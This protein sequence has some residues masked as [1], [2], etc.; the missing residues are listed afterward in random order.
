MATNQTNETLWSSKSIIN[1]ISDTPSN[2]QGTASVSGSNITLG[3]LSSIEY[4]YDFASS[5][6][7]LRANSLLVKCRA[8]CSNKELETRYT[9]HLTIELTIRYWKE[10]QAASGGY[11]EGTWSK[12]RV[13]PY[14]TSEDE[15]YVLD[16]PVSIK[17][18]YIN[19]II[20]KAMTDDIG[21]NTVELSNFK[22]YWEL[23]ISEVIGEYAGT[24]QI[25][26]VDTYDNG[27]V[28]YYV[29]DDMPVTL[30]VQEV[31]TGNYLIDVSGRYNFPIVIHQGEIPWDNSQEG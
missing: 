22:V 2:K 7:T 1:V 13:Y 3:S 27:M 16:I 28:A 12:V 18:E 21:E 29:D 14:F 30:K 24:A 10:D 17:L 23:S 9:E 15:G 19:K 6:S 20:I 4:T 25:K 31:S 8:S 5:G 26:S 11:I